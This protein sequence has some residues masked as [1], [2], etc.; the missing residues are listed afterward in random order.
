MKPLLKA[1][2]TYKERDSA[3]KSKVTKRRAEFQK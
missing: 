2:Y 1:Q 3:A